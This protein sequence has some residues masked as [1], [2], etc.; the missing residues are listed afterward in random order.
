[1]KD[2]N[3]YQEFT[4]TTAKY[5]GAG[6]SNEHA[7][8]Y[9]TLGLAGES[10]EVADKIKKLIRDEGG[11]DRLKDLEPKTRLELVKELGDILWYISRMSDEL[12]FRLSEVAELNM[13]KLSSRKAR[14]VIHGSGDN[15]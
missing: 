3:S 1:M 8:I 9:C 13:A 10:G 5:P 2:F 14:G 11:F 6:T 12:G 4:K 7:L 15:R